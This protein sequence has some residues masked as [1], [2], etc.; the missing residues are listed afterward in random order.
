MKIVHVYDSPGSFLESI[1]CHLCLS[2]S[3]IYYK[4]MLFVVMKVR[5]NALFLN[6]LVGGTR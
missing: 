1:L 5:W 3:E 2:Y 6:Y 4:C